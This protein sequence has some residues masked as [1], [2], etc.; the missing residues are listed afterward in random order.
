MRWTSSPT[1]A[2]AGAVPGAMAAVA[3]T[4]AAGFGV[5]PSVVSES[6]KA[7]SFAAV[8]EGELAARE[9]LIEFGARSA[10]HPSNSQDF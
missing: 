6:L 3:T 4:V 9:A 2:T 7:A 8:R 10:G 5:S 1:N